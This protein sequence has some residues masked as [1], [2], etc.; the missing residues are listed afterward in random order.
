MVTV[1]PV[2]EFLENPPA[3]LSVEVLGSGYRVHSDPERSLVL[4]DDSDSCRGNIVF[5]N[6]LGSTRKSLLSKRIYLLVSACEETSSV[7]SKKAANEPRVLQRYVVSIDGNNPFIKWQVERG[8]DWTI[9]SVAGESYVVDIDLT[10]LME[11]WA[12][13]NLTT[14]KLIQV[15]HA[16]RDATFTLKYY[17]DALFD[18]P[19][20]FGFSKRTFKLRLT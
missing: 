3:G 2:E 15:K 7:T 14:D 11:S 1:T 10:E 13:K 17:S 19:F 18:F 9:S 20:W 5:Q 8:L 4:I 12:A 6:S 16:W